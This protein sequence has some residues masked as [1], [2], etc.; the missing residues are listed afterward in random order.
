MVTVL[1]ADVVGF[2][3]LAE[4]RDPEQVKRLIDGC[5]QRLA[6]DIDTHGGRVDKFLGD[7]VLAL[8]G[9]PTAHE[10]DAERGVRTG[11]AMQATV[12]AYAEQVGVDIRLRVGV[13]TGEVL[14]GALRAGGDYT[15]LGDVVNLASRLQSEA[16][17]G[18]VL[19]GPATY[20]ATR[21]AIAYDP[22]GT[23]TVRGRTEPV[24]T[25]LALEPMVLP[26]S[27][28]VGRRFPLVGRDGELSTL[29]AAAG[30]AIA[31]ARP[32]VIAIE[33]EGGMGKSR[34]AEEVADAVADRFGALTVAGRCLPYGETS[35]L[36]PLT[37]ALRPL[38]GLDEE[39]LPARSELEEAVRLLGAELPL[40]AERVVDAVLH[41]FGASSPLA[42]IEPA[43]ALDE[44]VRAL[45]AMLSSAARRR[46]VLLRIGDL[47]WADPILLDVL[48]RVL[49]QVPAVGF[50]LVT[51]AR[52]DDA[53][54][55]P[56]LDAR[57]STFLLRLD[58]LATED[59]DALA[60]LA[61]GD[62]DDPALRREVLTRSGGNPLFIEQLA[63][64][65][66]DATPTGSIPVLPDTL[67]G[68]VAA[69]LDA[70]TPS[71]RA[72]LDNA[73]VLGTTGRWFTL[74]R[75]GVALGQRPSR[76]TLEELGS[77]DLLV[78]EGNSWRFRS[79]TVREVAYQTLTKS[80]R[81]QRHAGVAIAIEEM[82][83]GKDDA[84]E[85]LA[86]HW[87]TAASL[88]VELGPVAR[89]PA[90]VV[91]RAVEWS[92]RAARHALSRQAYAQSE[93]F[94]DGALAL[95]DAAT[96]E[97]STPAAPTLDDDDVLPSRLRLLLVR[98]E[99]RIGLR[100]N[101]AARADL[102]TVL[103]AARGPVP[104]DVRDRATGHA[105]RLIGLLEHQLGRTD[106]ARQRLEEAVAV[107]RSTDDEAGLALA[108]RNLGMVLVIGGHFH[109]AE[110]PLRE[111]QDRYQQL[112]DRRGLAWVNQ[113]LAW[114]SFVGGDRAG[115]DARLD[116]AET[117]F[118][119]LGD[120]GGR[121][122]VLG[123][124]AFLRFQQGRLDEAE[125]LASNV[126]READEQNDRWAAAMMRTLLGG[127][128]LWSGRVADARALGEKAL[129]GFR[130]L[131]DR[132]GEGQAAAL[133]VRA[134][135]A[136]GEGGEPQRELERLAAMADT[137]PRRA[138]VSL[139]QAGAAV[140]LGEPNRAVAAAD[141]ALATGG[142]DGIGSGELWSALAL[143]RLQLG[144][145]D[146][147]LEA[148]ERAAD[149]DA[150]S[151]YANAGRAAA[152]TATG[153]L[154]RA[155]ELAAQVLTHAGS[156]YLDRML[157]AGAGAIA[158]L[159]EGEVE[160]AALL[161]A[162]ATATAEATEDAQAW[163]LARATEA[164]VEAART[165]GPL[166]LP[167]GILNQ[168]WGT[169]WSTMAAGA[170]AAAPGQTATSV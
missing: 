103:D 52:P 137:G 89:V 149:I 16:P 8:F 19:V 63:A 21:G 3:R 14:V 13:S 70:L 105:M 71:Q 81:A 109:E 101:E 61:L 25:W 35:P 17:P 91:E 146:G 88:V 139:V 119:G 84:A 86:H 117:T 136:A 93:R 148:A 150:D 24:E 30:V 53:S 65:V 147:A 135:I 22:A 40:P 49:A 39:G 131:G 126:L 158:R 83:K 48:S 115:A 120:P 159:G 140:H 60:S 62:E 121:A 38:L 54:A 57:H 125:A 113:H 51:T 157:A 129:A 12:A 15:A 111:A 162:E 28:R 82:A 107:L 11:L 41:L 44:V 5:F 132:Y 46:P 23:L 77:A 76:R 128:R 130:G 114:T 164:L 99:A 168:G 92:R 127:L 155:T 153:D 165:G 1:F 26:G 166:E 156:S 110:H 102:D 80:V 87:S 31:R 34:L 78:L 74:E 143:A 116:E 55:W 145:G 154:R 20:L 170:V 123:L 64:L 2:T 36:A 151:P 142:L 141:A 10:D 144:D 104:L 163:A 56:P 169:A 66:G 79:P 133:L 96:A 94:A 27:R 118:S 33:G 152:A 161:A 42:D 72:M 69:R 68:L 160:G 6:T 138:F 97:T 90:D 73:A 47:H 32:L 122:W 108:L 134:G 29:T 95:V 7:G 50:V 45:A 18:G 106:A 43:N 167:P 59:A 85:V 9:A 4:H 75:F 37:F 98:A 100:R 112:G 58:P 124:R 67:R